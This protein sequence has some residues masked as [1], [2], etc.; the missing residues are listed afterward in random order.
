[1]AASYFVKGGRP[2]LMKD[3]E[4]MTPAKSALS[5]YTM[6]ETRAEQQPATFLSAAEV[7]V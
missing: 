5:C 3:G 2:F 4:R 7:I 6:S 1:M